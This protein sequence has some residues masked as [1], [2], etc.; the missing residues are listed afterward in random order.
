MSDK[1]QVKT[2]SFFTAGVITT[3]SITLSLFLLGLVC[4]AAF[5]GKSFSNYIKETMALSI[6]IS[7]KTDDVS[8]AKLKTS[9]EKNPYIKSVEYISKEQIK[10]QLIKDLGRDPEEVLGYNPSSSYYDVYIKSE[11]VNPDSIKLVE[12]SL[13]G[14]KLVKNVVYDE[15]DIHQ[16]NS[17]L[18]KLSS[19]LLGLTA[20]L[21]L[22]SFTLI[23]NTIQL[24]IYSKRFL[25]N[26]MQL[27]GATNSFIR[28]PFVVRMMISGII[29]AILAAL[30]LTGII[31]YFVHE[32]PDLM[33]IVKFEEL[34]AV[35]ILMLI[36]GIL[37]SV[38]ATVSA[39]NR[40]LRMKT[41]KL[42][43]I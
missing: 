7:D 5:T 3:I 37:L 22:I 23:R 4:L 35:Y 18:S 25:I 26:T 28:K 2:V 16:A 29:S 38:V 27:V 13:K 8:L 36:F 31:Y 30:F 21:L 40:F 9:L 15:E 39:V 41:N 43:Y 32:Y 6:E 14:L 34:L 11:Y 17:N 20:I 12:A 24:N 19:V 33:D 42:Y 10:E 1:Q